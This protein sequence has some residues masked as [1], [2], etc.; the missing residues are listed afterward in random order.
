MANLTN[1]VSKI[2]ILSSLC[3]MCYDNPSIVVFDSKAIK[4]KTLV[5]SKKYDKLRGLFTRIAGVDGKVDAA[6]LQ[7][8]LTAALSKGMIVTMMVVRIVWG[9]GGGGGGGQHNG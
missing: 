8:M 6:E 4:T 3:S 9:G 1:P 5:D 2:H 7:D